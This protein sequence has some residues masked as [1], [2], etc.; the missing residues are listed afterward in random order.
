MDSKW[1]RHVGVWAVLLTLTVSSLGLTAVP[2]HLVHS[3]ATGVATG[4]LVPAWWDGQCDTNN[5]QQATRDA[6]HPDGIKAFPLGDPHTD[7]YRGVVVCGPRPDYDPS[8]Q[9]RTVYFRDTSGNKVSW[10]EYEWECV[11]LVMRYLYLAY[12]QPPYDAY[13]A[14]VV[15]HYSTFR[16]VSGT[17][18]V[19][20]DNGTAHKA[21]QPGDVISFGNAQL[22]ELPRTDP[23][24]RPG[25]TAIVKASIVDS[26]GNGTITILQQ[27]SPS[28]TQVLN[29]VSWKVADAGTN[30]P[31]LAWLHDPGPSGAHPGGLW[32]S[33]T[34]GQDVNGAIHFAAH[35]YPSRTGDPSVNFVNFTVRDNQGRFVQACNVPAAQANGDIFAC[36]VKLAS[37]RIAP[38]SIQV[39]FDVYD[40]AG[41]YNLSPNGVR[42]LTY[43]PP[44]DAAC[45]AITDFANAGPPASL[46]NQFV[47][48]GAAGPPTVP[49]PP[50]TLGFVASTFDEPE[51]GRPDLVIRTEILN[52]CSV[53][54]TEGDVRAFFAQQMPSTGGWFHSDTFPYKGNFDSLCGDP[55]CWDWAAFAS[56]A[57]TFA[58]LE[59]LHQAGTAVTYH[60]RLAKEWPASSS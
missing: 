58:S 56:D 51:V 36:D 1:M 5:Y 18:L 19:T 22:A 46:A 26:S 29:V 49:F 57:F 33:P 50:N 38:G 54:L 59:S 40:V 2:T 11:E 55:Y 42:V 12:G 17:H 24:F 3:Q 43:L 52:V 9:D 60:I 41:N 31:A 23:K 14:T 6:T 37:L 21:P 48:H 45:R 39:S 27:N 10:G 35:A 8:A 47:N 13:G 34:E 15:S 53:G 7:Q 32:V 20:V 28:P 44:P 30:L 4:D 16:S 25:H